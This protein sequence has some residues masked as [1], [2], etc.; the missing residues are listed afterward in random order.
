MSQWPELQTRF[1]ERITR[2]QARQHEQERRQLEVELY[3]VWAQA[4]IADAMVSL[5]RILAE[6]ASRFEKAIGCAFVVSKPTL[7]SLPDTEPLTT[8]LISQGA[9]RVYLYGQRR[10]RQTPAIHLLKLRQLGLRPDAVVSLP[11]ARLARGT[12]GQVEF[13]EFAPDN[14]S[15]SADGLAERAVRLLISGIC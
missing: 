12:E 4:A 13:R 5:H 9:T 7:V 14:A 6:Q 8:I 3:A 1:Q 11:G 15:S 10:P 2:V